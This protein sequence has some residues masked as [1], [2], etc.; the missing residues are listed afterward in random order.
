MS[1]ECATAAGSAS[2]T[3]SAGPECEASYR[4]SSQLDRSS[5]L[6]RHGNASLPRHSP[7]QPLEARRRRGWPRRVLVAAASVALLVSTL[8]AQGAS[9]AERSLA[10]GLIRTLWPG[11]VAAWDRHSS[12][13]PPGVDDCSRSSGAAPTPSGALGTAAARAASR[14]SHPVRRGGPEPT[15]RAALKVTWPLWTYL[16]DL[17]EPPP[18]ERLLPPPPPAP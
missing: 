12:V 11:T 3:E 18:P 13:L 17:R 6:S 10:A 5:A 8:A 7:P 4:P 2:R 16:W 14:G 9:G 1:G 15:F